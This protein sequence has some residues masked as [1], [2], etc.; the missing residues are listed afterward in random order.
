MLSKIFPHFD[1]YKIWIKTWRTLPVRTWVKAADLYRKGEFKR[2]AELY[3]IGL[4]KHPFHEAAYCARLDL[5]HCNF[6]LGKFI[7]S[8]ELLKN[9]ISQIPTLREA[10][11][12]LARVQMWVGES[13]EAAWTMRRA[14]REIKP[15]G[16]MIALFTGAVV[17]H[18]GASYLFKECEEAYQTLSEDERNN[19][20]LLVARA[21]LEITR[22]DYQ[23]GRAQLTSM[24]S[25]ADAPIEAVIAYGELLIKEGRVPM[26]RL[27]LRRALSVMPNNP[28]ILTLMAELYLKSGTEFNPEFA[29]QN[30]TAACQSSGWLSPEALHTL[31][32]AFKALDD[33]LSALA[34]AVRAREAGS[35]L[36]S[37]YKNVKDVNALIDSLATAKPSNEQL[38]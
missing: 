29:K 19:K 36:L 23:K 37:G 33:R 14:I 3:E 12:R 27:Q 7:E 15:D 24:V 6:K 22:G 34:T 30:A 31:A 28:K 35:K 25:G 26:A 21:R 2:A 17:E 4:S 20:K 16:E 32:E 11:I 1:S 38:S 18:G 8:K 5:A 9:L 10:Y 13:L